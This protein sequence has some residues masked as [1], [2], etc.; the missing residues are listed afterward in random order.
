MS[1]FP[2]LFR[3]YILEWTNNNYSDLFEEGVDLNYY[4]L[5]SSHVGVKESVVADLAHN[6]ASYIP[7][8]VLND[9]GLGI[10]I[11][12]VEITYTEEKRALVM[13]ID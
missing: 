3:N 9:M 1:E 12:E 10:Q 6:S 5:Y 13:L 4:Q 2:I 7:S 11:A 8:A